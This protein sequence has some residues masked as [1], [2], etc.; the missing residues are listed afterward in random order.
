MN[1]SDIDKN[2]EY[3][4]YLKFLL[5]YKVEESKKICN[6]VFFIFILLILFGYFI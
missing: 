6:N 3:Y 4:I 1:K 5:T 2:I